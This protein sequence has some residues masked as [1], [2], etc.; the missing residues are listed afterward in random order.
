MSSGLLPPNSV[1]AFQEAPW[2][3]V[4]MS[5]NWVVPLSIRSEF[6][7]R[8]FCNTKMMIMGVGCSWRRLSRLLGDTELGSKVK[9]LVSVRGPVSGTGHQRRTEGKGRNVAPCPGAPRTQRQG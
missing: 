1:E 8:P 7:Q 5:E 4:K 3:P 2:A 6:M 9:T